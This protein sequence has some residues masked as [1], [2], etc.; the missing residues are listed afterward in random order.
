MG[1]YHAHD[2]ETKEKT[3]TE[4]KKW[5]AQHKRN[6]II[7]GDFNE[8][9]SPQDSSSHDKTGQKIHVQKY[10]G[11]L[12]HKLNKWGFMDL[13]TQ[14]NGDRAEHTHVKETSM[15][16]CKSRLDYIYGTAE[17]V[18]KCAIFKTLQINIMAEL[19]LTTCP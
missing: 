18:D 4:V 14:T 7:M 10:S 2:K 12:H 8:L 19:M 16:S 6:A 13:K 9:A 1:L 15:G 3:T 17:I 5:C 11:A